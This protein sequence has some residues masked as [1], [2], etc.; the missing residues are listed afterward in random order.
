MFDIIVDIDGTLSELSH[1]Q[2]YLKMTPK[3]WKKFNSLVHLDDTHDDIIWI[4]K[5][6]KMAGARIIICTAR[7]E[8]IKEPT[9]E[10][11]NDKAGLAG[12]YD[13]IYMRKSKD[14]RND[15]IVKTELL[16]QMRKDG[17]NPTIVFDDRN[18]AVDAWRSA[19]LR[20]LQVA[21]GDF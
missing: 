5:T 17:F 9:I 1:R 15:G 19:G 4:I 21:P 12:F 6:L 18:K 14:Y 16:E 11:L 8:D 3:N 20:C 13:A 2:E 10:W 7:T